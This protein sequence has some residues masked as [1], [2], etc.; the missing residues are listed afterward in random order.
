MYA[1]QCNQMLGQFEEALAHY[2][3]GQEKNKESAEIYFHRGLAQVSLNEY[4][5]G[6]KDFLHAFEKAPSQGLLK[7][8]ILLNLGINYRRIGKLDES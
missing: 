2:N 4:D 5:A 1:G 6:I 3:Y 7:F 8:K